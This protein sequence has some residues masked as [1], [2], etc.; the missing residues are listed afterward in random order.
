MLFAAGQAHFAGYAPDEEQGQQCGG[1][2]HVGVQAAPAVV[3][4]GAGEGD[5]VVD[6]DCVRLHGDVGLEAV[7]LEQQLESDIAVLEQDGVA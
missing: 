4:F 6:G 5:L 1:H 3:A 2:G 7:A